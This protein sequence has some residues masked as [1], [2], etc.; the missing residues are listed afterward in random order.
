MGLQLN[1]ALSEFPRASRV[2]QIS[3]Q[4][5]CNRDGMGT[6]CFAKVSRLH[7]RRRTRGTVV[8]R[9]ADGHAYLQ[10]WLIVDIRNRESAPRRR[11]KG[12][13]VAIKTAGNDVFVVDVGVDC[14]PLIS[15]IL[16]ILDGRYSLIVYIHN[17]E[18]T[19]GEKHGEWCRR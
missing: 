7:G 19:R 3:P 12:Q 14:I 11:R 2:P 1:G 15:S 8:R 13:R 6:V 17:W 10:S 16:I 18:H 5:I 9:S 4:R